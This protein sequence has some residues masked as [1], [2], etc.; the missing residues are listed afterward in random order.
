MSL[1]ISRWVE[2]ARVEAPTDAERTP[3]FWHWVRTLK[4]GEPGY[5]GR[6]GP[7]PYTPSLWRRRRSIPAIACSLYY[8]SW[9]CFSSKEQDDNAPS[10]YVKANA[11]FYQADKAK[12]ERLIGLL[13]FCGV[14]E[15]LARGLAREAWQDA[16]EEVWR[17]WST[18]PKKKGIGRDLIRFLGYEIEDEED[19]GYF[20]T[21]GASLGEFASKEGI[22][23]R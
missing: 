10:G 15:S 4:E 17:Q 12:V 18:S 20:D 19:D 22:K 23:G 7:Q 9:A 8:T 16:K 13:V 11:L 5:T 6:R 1:S 21:L 3:H 14:D 2:P